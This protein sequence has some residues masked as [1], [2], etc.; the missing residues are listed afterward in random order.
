MSDVGLNPFTLTPSAQWFFLPPFVAPCT[1]VAAALFSSNTSTPVDPS[2]WWLVGLLFVVLTV[3]YGICIHK[4]LY[5]GFFPVQLTAQGLLLCPIA[6]SLGAKMLQWV[7]VIMAICG[8]VILLA[9]YC[10]T[11]VAPSDI[12]PE[13]AATPASSSELDKL[14][15][16]CAVTDRDGDVLFISDAL[17]RLAQISRADIIGSKIT[18]FLALDKENVDIGGKTWQILHA[19]MEGGKHCFQLEEVRNVVVMSPLHSDGGN[20]FIDAETSLYTRFYAIKRVEQELYRV[21]RYQRGMSIALLRMSFRGNGKPEEED[22]IF[23]IYCRF[24]RTHTRVADVPCVVASRDILVVLPETPLV[25]AEEVIGRLVDVNPRAQEELAPFNG[26][27]K[28]QKSVAYWDSSSEDAFL[29][30]VLE[31]LNT[32]LET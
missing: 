20:I 24:I 22:N 17:L 6:L 19:G 10:Q 12:A 27:Y 29:D 4:N 25:K 31:K 15:L 23:Q 9:L 26:I 13:I 16:P 18:S 1:V 14:P 28:V 5:R 8:A 30:Q 2:L 11:H 21:R 3:F 32:A 7:G